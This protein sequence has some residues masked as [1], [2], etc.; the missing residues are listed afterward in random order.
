MSDLGLYLAGASDWPEYRRIVRRV[1]MHGDG[2]SGHD[3]FAPFRVEIT[4]LRHPIT[5][6]L[7]AFD[8]EALK[9]RLGA[10]RRYL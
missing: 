6:G 10:L 1:W 3:A 4:S 5:Q 2:G 7:Q 9:G 8:T